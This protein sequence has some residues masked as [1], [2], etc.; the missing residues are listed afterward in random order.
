MSLAIRRLVIA[1]P[2]AELAT[3]AMLTALLPALLASGGGTLV[4]QITEAQRL[5]LWVGPIGGFL[6][7]TLA[8]WW[9]ARRAS[10]PERNGLRLG[11]TVAVLDLVLLVVSGAP[12]G[13]LMILSVIGRVAGGYAGG[14]W[15]RRRLTARTLPL[16]S[17]TN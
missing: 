14:W 1:A 5:G 11:V 17:P 10:D 7:C 9:V 2:L 6:L 3:V 12:L 4:Y 8:G 16:V 15:A 13:A